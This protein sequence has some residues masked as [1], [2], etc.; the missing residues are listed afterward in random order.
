M[1][2]QQNRCGSKNKICSKTDRTKFWEKVNMLVN[3]IYSLSPHCFRKASLLESLN[4]GLRG[5]SLPIT[6]YN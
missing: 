3:H 5:K 6:N 2:R 4:L 1:L